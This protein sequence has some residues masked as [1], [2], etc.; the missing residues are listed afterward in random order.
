MA[1]NIYYE[2]CHEDSDKDWYHGELTRDQAE[3]SLRASGSNCFL[4]RESKGSLVLSLL[5]H[6]Q[7]H[8]LKIK[9]GPRWYSL[10]GRSSIERF[11]D[12]NEL[13]SY[14]CSVSASGE[15][16]TLK[17]ASKTTHHSNC[18]GKSLSGLSLTIIT[19]GKI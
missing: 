8:H 16:L 5:L 1:A 9:H 11:S 7:I 10:E 14:H 15:I 4:I 19:T 3:E 2:A 13:V 6:G 12:L 18:T 17:A